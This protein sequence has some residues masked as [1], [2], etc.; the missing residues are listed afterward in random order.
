MKATAI[1][2]SLFASLLSALSY[3]ANPGEMIK[4]GPIIMSGVAAYPFIVW[5]VGK[6][7]I[8]SFMKLQVTSGYELLEARFGLTVRLLGAS[9]F[10][11]L[12]LLWMSVII[13]ATTDKVLIPLTGLDP[14]F[15]PWLCLAVGFVTVIYT[16]AGGL[17]AVVFTDVAQTFILFPGCVTD[18]DGD[19]VGS[20]Q[21]ERVVA[22][23]VAGELG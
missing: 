20:R 11:A 15:K 22:T 19:H 21:R 6:F 4:Y 16:S 13:Y 18:L 3:L 12:R 14:A 7:I 17:R 1:G 5:A 2:I 23:G 10:L 9:F 8:P